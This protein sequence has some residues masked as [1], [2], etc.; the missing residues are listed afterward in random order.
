ME[1]IS[2]EQAVEQ[3]LQHTPVINETEATELNKAGGRVLAP[4]Q[5]D[6]CLEMQKSARII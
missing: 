2:V 1:G 5:L 6:G 3:I 4:R